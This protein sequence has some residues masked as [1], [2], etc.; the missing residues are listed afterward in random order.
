MCFCRLVLVQLLAS[1]VLATQVGNAQLPEGKPSPA[2]EPPLSVVNAAIAME[3]QC[4]ERLFPA[5][6]ALAEKPLEHRYVITLQAFDRCPQRQVTVS[7]GMGEAK[8]QIHETVGADL[9]TQLVGILQGEGKHRNAEAACS[10]LDVEARIDEGSMAEEASRHV[11]L[12][13]DKRFSIIQ[14]NS[15]TLD[16]KGYYRLYV[17]TPFSDAT[18]RFWLASSLDEVSNLEEW[19]REMLRIVGLE[20]KSEAAS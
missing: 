4:L 19:A 13:E 18:F 20:C 17:T 2:E 16:G 1:I 9:Q 8:V 14:D 15:L 10:K 7:V 6:E 5:H 12:L 3:T 11:S